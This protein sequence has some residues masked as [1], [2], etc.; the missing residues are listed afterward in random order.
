MASKKNEDKGS[1]FYQMKGIW[2]PYSLKHPILQEDEDDQEETPKLS[3]QEDLVT[4]GNR[5]LAQQKKTE[6]TGKS[7]KVPYWEETGWKSW[8]KTIGGILV[9]LAILVGLGAFVVSHAM[10]DARNERQQEI[11]AEAMSELSSGE[12]AA[13]GMTIDNPMGNK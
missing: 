10:R 1:P 8:I 9:A 5:I 11:A 3:E 12:N 2:D 6:A 13:G 4:A 7:D